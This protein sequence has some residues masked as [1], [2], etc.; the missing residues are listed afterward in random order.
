MIIKCQLFK[1]IHISKILKNIIFK[2]ANLQ[3]YNILL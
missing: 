3:G 2:T 1:Y